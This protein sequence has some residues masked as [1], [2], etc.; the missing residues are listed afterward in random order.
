MSPAVTLNWK[1]NKV[2]IEQCK[3]NNMEVFKLSS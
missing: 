2:I 3:I 1:S